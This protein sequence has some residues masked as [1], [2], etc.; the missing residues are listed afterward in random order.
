[1]IKALK[2][3]EIFTP[4]SCISKGVYFDFKSKS[5]PGDRAKK[6]TS[7]RRD[8]Q[9]AHVYRR[10]KISIF[11]LNFISVCAFLS[12]GLPLPSLSPPQLPSLS[13]L[14]RSSIF[15]CVYFAFCLESFS[16][17]LVK[18]FEIQK[19]CFSCCFFNRQIDKRV[20]QVG[21]WPKGG[22]SFA[23]FIFAYS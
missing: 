18:K 13:A 1:M 9:N 10:Q 21:G 6:H 3:S 15:V 12:L 19:K 16:F 5:D 22:G 11:T 14:D 20:T 23:L 2:P 17:W 4:F 8:K 7:S